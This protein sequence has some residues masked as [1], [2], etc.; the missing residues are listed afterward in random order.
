[1]AKE[2]YC[3]DCGTEYWGSIKNAKCGYCEH[4]FTKSDIIFQKRLFEFI[5]NRKNNNEKN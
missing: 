3:P 5:D 1:M 4:T 2:L